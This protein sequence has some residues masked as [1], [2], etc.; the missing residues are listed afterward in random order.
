M[1]IIEYTILITALVILFVGP[2]LY[3]VE[4]RNRKALI[5]PWRDFI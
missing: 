4:K 3:E 1:I 2:L 5:R